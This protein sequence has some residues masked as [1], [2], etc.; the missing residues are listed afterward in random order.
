MRKGSTCTRNNIK[1]QKRFKTVFND[2][3]AI[4]ELEKI[5]RDDFDSLDSFLAG[6]NRPHYQ[7]EKA[8]TEAEGAKN[9]EEMQKA[10]EAHKDADPKA[11]GVENTEEAHKANVDDDPVSVNASLQ[12]V[13]R[14]LFTLPKALSDKIFATVKVEIALLTCYVSSNCAATEPLAKYNS[15]K[16]EERKTLK[17]LK[18]EASPSAATDLVA[19]YKAVR[20]GSVWNYTKLQKRFKAFFDDPAKLKDY[21]KQERDEFDSLDSFLGSSS[22]TDSQS[23]EQA[24]RKLHVKERKYK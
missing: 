11:E 21:E 8:D 20:K 7:T 4:R 1:L 2:A 18:D 19:K 3:A 24:P 5:E 9:T 12:V 16:E 13:K 10:E 6:S 15:A 17:K 14:K 22:H 23:N